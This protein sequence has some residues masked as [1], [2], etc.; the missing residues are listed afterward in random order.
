[1]Y[2]LNE[3]LFLSIS[4][5]VSGINDWQS[6]IIFGEEKLEWLRTFYPYHHGIP[7]VDTLER[8]FSALDPVSF[9]SCFREWSMK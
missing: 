5:L 2:P 3:L 4:A 9:E 1:M 7:S 8:L 6:T